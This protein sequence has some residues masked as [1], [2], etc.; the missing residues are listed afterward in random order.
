MAETHE[1]TVSPRSPPK[2]R[3]EP[4]EQGWRLLEGDRAVREAA[5]AA[6]RDDSKEDMDVCDSEAAYELG[7]IAV[8]ASRLCLYCGGR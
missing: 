5:V 3:N 1:S 7:A 8:Q 6:K 4:G 2:A